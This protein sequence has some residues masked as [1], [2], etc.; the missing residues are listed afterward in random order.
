MEA[1]WSLLYGARN[2]G[3]KKKRKKYNIGKCQLSALT[4]VLILAHIFVSVNSS[5][6]NNNPRETKPNM[7]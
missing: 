6:H 5:Y 2:I 7:E 3:L 1:A 4:A